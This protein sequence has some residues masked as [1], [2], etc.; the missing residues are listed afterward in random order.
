MEDNRTPHQIQQD[1]QVQ[2]LRWPILARHY[3]KV[4][5]LVSAEAWPALVAELQR[6]RQMRME[7]LSRP[8]LPEREADEQR[9]AISVLNW[10]L[11]L[12]DDSK[13]FPK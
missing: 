13:D 7:I 3:F 5:Q 10:L 11:R 2:L 9:G 8:M 1:Q 12:E 6:D 4:S